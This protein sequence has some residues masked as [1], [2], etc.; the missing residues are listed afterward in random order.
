MRDIKKFR[1]TPFQPNKLNSTSLWK[2]QQKKPLVNLIKS[3]LRKQW[4]L[5][6][7]HSKSNP[8]PKVIDDYLVIEIEGNEKDIKHTINSF[9]TF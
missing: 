9:N 6:M 3:L 7:Y 4:G 1:R 2:P 5:V 8:F